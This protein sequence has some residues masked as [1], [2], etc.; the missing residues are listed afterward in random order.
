M[1][2]GRIPDEAV[3]ICKDYLNFTRCE[4]PD[5][6][7]Y[8]TGGKCRKGFEA[9]K[10][11]ADKIA[12]VS[13][14]LNSSF[15][16]FLSEF[17]QSRQQIMDES[18]KTI[19][20]R[21]QSTPLEKLDKYDLQRLLSAKRL[22]VIV[23]EYQQLQQLGEKGKAATKAISSTKEFFDDMK[24]R[25]VN[26]RM[27]IS[28]G[29]LRAAWEGLPI[30]GKAKDVYKNGQYGQSLAVVTE[31]PV[32]TAVMKKDLLNGGPANVKNIIERITQRNIL[33][34]TSAP[35][36][37]RLSAGGFK[38]SMPDEKNTFSRYDASKVKVFPLSMNSKTTA[39]VN[40]LTLR[41]TI[42]KSAKEAKENGKTFE[43]W[44]ATQIDI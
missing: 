12:R 42:Q 22:A 11:D 16:D 23:E 26:E 20:Q 35:E 28:E 13:R 29:T 14:A 7:A 27:M 19:S 15:E 2:I 10:P 33:S 17:G 44:A 4:R 24:W 25:L 38:S 8:G 34:C 41:V 40:P 36:D 31:H 30:T 37:N 43:E 1:T 5:G 3:Q 39:G 32:P 18:A 9:E 21:I 6:T